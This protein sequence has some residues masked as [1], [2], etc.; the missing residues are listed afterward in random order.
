MNSNRIQG[1]LVRDLYVF[2]DEQHP[3]SSAA[4]HV[5][6]STI[7]D[8]VYDQLSPDN[9]NL[10]RILEELHQEIISGGIGN[11][12]FPVT[13]VNTETGDVWLTKRHVGLSEVDNTADIDKPL[14]TPQRDAIMNILKDYN[15][16][17][18]L[19]DLYNHITDNA[20]PHGVTFEQINHN[21]TVDRFVLNYIEKHNI[22]RDS[23]IHSDIRGSLRRLWILVDNITKDVDNKT[24]H[25]LS[26]L[27]NHIDDS[28]A[29][30]KLFT[31]K[32]NNSNKV[33][34]F[35]KTTNCDHTKYPSTRAVVEYVVMAIDKFNQTLPKVKHWIDTIKVIDTKQHLPLASEAE[36][37]NAYYIKW[38]G[39]NPAIAL[40]KQNLETMKYE[41]DI[42]PL[43]TYSKFN[44]RHFI[45]SSDG[46]SINLKGIS[47]EILGEDGALEESI[48]SKLDDYYN[49]EDIDNFKF[50]NQ[51]K[52]LP[53][54]TYGTIRF[55]VND[56][57]STMS[58]DI[59][60]A[61]L[62]RLAYLNYVTED[63]ISDNAVH[64][65][66]I[67]SKSI[68]N[69]H[70]QD[71]AVKPTNIECFNG[72]IIGNDTDTE[73][74]T[75]NLISF[76]QLADYLRPLIGGWPDPT[77][78]GGNPW[79]D[80]LSMQLMQ[81]QNWM[82][83]V[84]YP[85]GNGGYGIR[86]TGTIS[87]LPNVNYK[88]ELTPNINLKNGMQLFGAG[89]SFEYQSEPDVEWTVLG[90]TNLTGHTFG[91]VTMDSKGLY[92]ES[93]ST[94]NRI[95]AKY[96]IWVKYIKPREVEITPVVPPID[97]QP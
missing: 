21:N 34:E 75:A 35:N 87:C 47:D 71:R 10:R 25:A 94:G 37:Y 3:E 65:H 68:A 6:P 40:C 83:D 57:M 18:N 90:G 80:K 72:F 61:G 70:I 52:M 32:E 19:S 9:K 59:Y 79:Y 41:W 54:T 64:E 28:F 43:S 36:L 14:S 60:V 5:Q 33:V 96:D 46:L 91:T 16:E 7:L 42:T 13:S 30:D 62:K 77:V 26:E 48:D 49:K 20:N 89:G 22:S 39:N 86:F 56:D 95:N 66:H 24:E 51:I 53:G 38:E 45:D 4:S 88:L 12:K 67:L 69:K 31:L 78:P 1:E 84:D 23:S 27:K 73:K 29:H 15:F 44:S 74:P 85:F 93:I 92:F 76:Q 63:E 50:I 82:V 8:Q 58:E 2:E 97:Y 17:V 11:I 81:T 55:Y